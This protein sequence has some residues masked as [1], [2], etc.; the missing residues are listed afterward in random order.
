MRL[1]QCVGIFSYHAI[2]VHFDSTRRFYV[3][4]CQ[5][6]SHE[7]SV[8]RHQ[9]HSLCDCGLYGCKG[10]SCTLDTYL[11]I[12]MNRSAQRGRDDGEENR[13]AARGR[14]DRQAL[15]LCGRD[16][17]YLSMPFSICETALSFVQK[18]FPKDST[19]EQGRCRRTHLSDRVFYRGVSGGLWSV[20]GLLCRSV[21]SFFSPYGKVLSVRLRRDQAKN[22]KVRLCASTNFVVRAAR[23]TVVWM[24]VAV[25][26][27]LQYQHLYQFR[28]RTIW[29]KRQST[30]VA[31]GMILT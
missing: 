18:G 5:F 20:L 9:S 22:F 23:V 26:V 16:S 17:R 30:I 13:S 21:E 2:R 14:Y 1:F 10:M 15:H 11:R 12:F 7:G 29:L 19:I 25:L 3:Y 27:W 24:A 31:R 6:Q 8:D 28:W 4:N